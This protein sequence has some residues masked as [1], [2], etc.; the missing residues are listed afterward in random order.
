MKNCFA[1]VGSPCIALLLALPVAQVAAQAA[2]WNTIVNDATEA[3]DGRPGSTFF[4]Y[5]Q[6][7][8]NDDGLIVFRAR[9][10]VGTGSF[11]TSGIYRIDLGTGI[12]ERLNVRGDEV[13]D[14]NNT[15]VSGGFASFNDFPST[16][17]LDPNGPLAASRG[18]HEPV[19]TYLE[20]EDET[21]VGTAGVYVYR[22]G[23][24]PTTGASQL[25]A[26]TEPDGV[27]LTFPWFSVPQTTLGTRFDQFPGAPGVSEPYIVYKG[28]YVDQ[29]DLLGRT[30]IY[31]R[32]VTGISPVP[33]TGMVASSETVIPNQPAGGTVP[34]GST[35]PPSAANGWVYFVGF[36]N[37]DAPSLGGVYRAPIA[38]VP[39]LEVIEGVGDPV[40][41]EGGGAF[42]ARFGEGLSLTSD[43][44]RVSFWASWGTQTFVKELQCPV[45]GRPELIA[46]CNELFPGGVTSVEVPVNQG[47][48]VHDVATG[49]THRVARTGEEGIEDFLFWGFSGRTPSELEDDEELARWRSSAFTA[50]NSDTADPLLAFKAERDGTSGIYLREGL[51]FQLPLRMIAEVG[52][53]PGQDVDIAAPADSFVSEVGVERDGFR[54]N[55]LAINVGMLFEDPIDPEETEGWAGM[56]YTEVAADLVFQDGFESP[57]VSD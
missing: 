12:V 46:Y 29:T 33:F 55:R 36:D 27:T 34:F 1:F 6:P 39:A 28:N 37:E 14:P 32:N 23:Q 5:N 4:S 38:S 30:G 49:R 45:D 21:R 11:V 44:T 40:P 43:G 47:L 53:T 57:V 42:F 2:G 22:P 7:S 26:A 8:L 48:F 19:W 9:S 24:I 10:H 52:T 35:A 50:L 56:Y 3:P 51:T 17:R 31:F 20:G 16:P 18:Q 54:R 15:I 25:G 13:P 41:G